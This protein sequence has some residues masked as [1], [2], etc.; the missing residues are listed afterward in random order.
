PGQ[1]PAGV[2]QGAAAEH[3]GPLARGPELCQRPARQGRGPAE[4][5]SG[6]RHPARGHSRCRGGQRQAPADDRRRRAGADAVRLPV[7]GPG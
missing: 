2:P 5:R 1:R 3:R 4:E 6:A 7:P